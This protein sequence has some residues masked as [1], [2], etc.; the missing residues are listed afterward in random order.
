M[1]IFFCFSSDKAPGQN[2]GL[3]G[4][5][6]LGLGRLTEDVSSS[7]QRFLT[8]RSAPNFICGLATC[9]MALRT[10]LPSVQRIF[11]RTGPWS[12][13][14]DQGRLFKAFSGSFCQS[15]SLPSIRCS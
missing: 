10:V 4:E 14:K 12:G 7:V 15:Q 2:L 3:I 9:N 11:R 13:T 5:R 6:V 8:S 1:T